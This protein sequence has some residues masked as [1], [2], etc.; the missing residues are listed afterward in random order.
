MLASYEV[1]AGCPH[2]ANA[3]TSLQHHSHRP[4]LLLQLRRL[5]LLQRRRLLILLDIR[6][7]HCFLDRSTNQL[8]FFLF[9]YST[10]LRFCHCFFS[11]DEMEQQ[12]LHPI[13]MA[14]VIWVP[15]KDGLSDFYYYYFTE[16]L[17]HWDSLGLSCKIEMTCLFSLKIIIMFV[18]S[19]YT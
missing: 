17:E 13:D 19:M 14:S 7:F 18:S 8:I 12:K 4:R 3:L 6:V 1:V 11:T 5:R 9:I 10:I 2:S 15:A 16:R